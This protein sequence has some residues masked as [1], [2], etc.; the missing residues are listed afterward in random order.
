[1]AL[2]IDSHKEI[3]NLKDSDLLEWFQDG[4]HFVIRYKTLKD[5]IVA[6]V[7]QNQ[8]NY[9]VYSFLLTQS[10]TSAPTMTVIENTLGIADVSWVRIG[11]GNYESSAVATFTPTTTFILSAQTDWAL[12]SG[13]ILSNK[14]SIKTIDTTTGVGTDGALT[15]LFFELRVYS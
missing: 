4:K 13:K 5:K 8:G 1:M 12:V 9:S 3:A 11:A 2:R 15:N 7:P 10:G 14:I 6:A